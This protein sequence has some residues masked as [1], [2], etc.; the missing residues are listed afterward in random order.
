MNIKNLA[1]RFLKPRGL[2]IQGFNNI[3]YDSAVWGNGKTK[4]FGIPIQKCP[5]DLWIYQE[6]IFDMKPDLIIETGT[7]DGGS[8]LFLAHLFDLIGKGK[9]ISVDIEAKQRPKHDRITY[10]TGSSTT[11][12]IIEYLK[13]QV[14]EKEKVLVILDSDHSK[15]HVLNELQIYKDFVTQDSFLIVE[16][17]N[18]NGHPVFPSFGPGPTEAIDEFLKGNKEFVVDKTME[19]FFLTFNPQGYLRRVKTAA[20]S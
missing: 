20:P 16:D 14:K 1:L 18:I 5:T 9:I 15:Q 19:K 2:I 11:D 12:E 13:E 7:A 8:T 4:W 6:I 3:Y 10:L 17:T